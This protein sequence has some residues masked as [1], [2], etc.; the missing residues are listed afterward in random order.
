MCSPTDVGDAAGGVS[1]ADDWAGIQVR[2]LIKWTRRIRE[3]VGRTFLSDLDGEEC[4]SH[5]PT[6]HSPS[7]IRLWRTHHSTVGAPASA[8]PVRVVGGPVNGESLVASG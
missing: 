8:G 2:G 5:R 1:I 6:D 4:P 7:K 3:M